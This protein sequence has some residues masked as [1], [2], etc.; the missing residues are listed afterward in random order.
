LRGIETDDIVQHKLQEAHLIHRGGMFMLERDEYVVML[1]QISLILIVI[2][3]NYSKLFNSFIVG[4]KNVFWKLSETPKK[5]F[6]SLS[7]A[8]IKTIAHCHTVALKIHSVILCDKE[9]MERKRMVQVVV[10]LYIEQLILY[11]NTL[12]FV[13]Y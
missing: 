9:S 5:F 8:W 11:H 7:T 4:T 13:A 12:Y 6:P 10:L 1:K 3:V 2:L